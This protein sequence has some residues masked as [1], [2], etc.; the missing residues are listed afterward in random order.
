MISHKVLVDPYISRESLCNSGGWSKFLLLDLCYPDSWGWCM[1]QFDLYIFSKVLLAHHPILPQGR[2]KPFSPNCLAVYYFRVIFLPVIV[3][4][5]GISLW[6]PKPKTESSLAVSVTGRWIPQ[7]VY[8]AKK[9]AITYMGVS[10]NN[11]TPKWMVYI[12]KPY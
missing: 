8:L 1:I 2:W 7:N 5:E 11:G 9:K 10:E 12:G 3:R 4:S 6:S